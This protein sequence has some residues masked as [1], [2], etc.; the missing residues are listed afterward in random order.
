MAQS[1]TDLLAQYRSQAQAPQ[2]TPQGQGV[3]SQNLNAQ[4]TQAQAYQTARQGAA[5]AVAQAQTDQM[6]QQALVM[7]GQEQR[8]QLNQ[9][10]LADKNTYAQKAQETLSQLDNN[11]LQLGEKDKEDKM[12]MAAKDIRLSN[13]KYRYN[14]EDI[15][16]R[17]RLD[18]AIGMNEA[19]KKSVWA[20][21]LGI[22]Q[23]NDQMQRALEA[24][25]G[26]FREYLANIDVGSAFSLAL[27]EHQIAAMNS[28]YSGIGSSVTTAAGLA[29]HQAMQPKTP[30]SNYPNQQTTIQDMPDQ[31]APSDTVES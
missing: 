12:E 30:T 13:D 28:V 14:L 25:E 1:F 18:T 29:A 17:Q 20:E 27:E 10:Q 16:R 11:M 24:D 5:G 15:G 9:Q 8:Q 26:S 3:Q 2:E 4:Y 31:N 6:Q 22:L 19:I 21:D 23:S 7:Q